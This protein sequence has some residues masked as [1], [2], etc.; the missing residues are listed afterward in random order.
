MQKYILDVLNQAIVL[1]Q[2]TELDTLEARDAAKAKDAYNLTLNQLVSRHQW[3]FLTREITVSDAMEEAPS[4]SSFRFKYRFLKPD[5]LDQI[6]NVKT[7]FQANP[8]LFQQGIS[9][10][11]VDNVL[12][13]FPASSRIEVYALIGNYIYT[14]IKPFYMVYLLNPNSEN[15]YISFSTGFT[16]AL[17]YGI[18]ANLAVS[19]TQSQS[20]FQ[21]LTQRFEVEARLA[22]N[23]DISQY[24]FQIP[25]Q[26]ESPVYGNRG[27]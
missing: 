26:G 25:N 10:T 9:R 12:G 11:A 8:S 2:G 17:V 1:S 14:N 23:R 16:A 21:R 3:S 20:L 27:I 19:G 6:L 4:T 18:A 13:D 15:A 24:K 5:G 7:N 22:I